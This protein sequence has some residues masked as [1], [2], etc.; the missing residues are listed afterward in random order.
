MSDSLVDFV[1][2]A[3]IRRLSHQSS[4]ADLILQKTK[5]YMDCVDLQVMMISLWKSFFSN[6]AVIG[7]ASGIG[8]TDKISAISRSHETFI[9]LVFQSCEDVITADWPPIYPTRSCRATE[10]E[11]MEARFR[12]RMLERLAGDQAELVIAHKVNKAKLQAEATKSLKACKSVPG[13]A[14]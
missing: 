2:A 3:Q 7:D 8:F 4:D 11:V 14:E 10:Y 1:L 12:S 9:M 13:F 6:E 5:E